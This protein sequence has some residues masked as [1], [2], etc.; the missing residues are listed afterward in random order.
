MGNQTQRCQYCEFES[1]KKKD[2]Y[3]HFL[4]THL[5]SMGVDGKE[6]W[7]QCFWCES[8]CKVNGL[9]R[10]VKKAHQREYQ[11]KL[12]CNFC[13][14]ESSN[15]MD[16]YHHHMMK[17]RAGFAK[18]SLVECPWC[19]YKLKPSDLEGHVHKSHPRV[20]CFIV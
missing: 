17:H 7:I 20:V 3:R 19:S 2:M 8:K 4:Q 9:R 15:R 12:E 10:H 14:H 18:N 13:G 16:L 6:S 5:E 1:K 11:N